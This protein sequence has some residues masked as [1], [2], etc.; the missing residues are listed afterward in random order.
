MARGDLKEWRGGEDQGVIHWKARWRYQVDVK[1]VDQHLIHRLARWSRVI[2]L[3]AC[4]QDRP[5]SGR[6][7][8][9]AKETKMREYDIGEKPGKGHYCCT[10]CHWRVYLD[11]NSDVLPPCGICGRNQ[12]T[13]YKRCSGAS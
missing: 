5:T 10:K 7:R 3:S 12:R 6:K 13:K 9:N 11:D 8:W 4:V 2:S 1:G